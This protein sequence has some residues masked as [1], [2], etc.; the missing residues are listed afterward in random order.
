MHTLFSTG[1][2]F[3]SSVNMSNDARMSFSASNKISGI[4]MSRGVGAEGPD[5]D[6]YHIF[7]LPG[8][9]RIAAELPMV[10]GGTELVKMWESTADDTTHTSFMIG[11]ISMC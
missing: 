2:T 9:M 8:V 3:I 7:E 5:L 1:G 4:P 10:R 6:V 11:C